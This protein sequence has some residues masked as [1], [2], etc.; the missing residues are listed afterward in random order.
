MQGEATDQHIQYF[1]YIRI[2]FLWKLSWREAN[3]RC[4]QSGGKRCFDIK[5]WFKPIYSFLL[6]DYFVNLSS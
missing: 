3:R 6:L 5:S 2:I 1:F 4:V